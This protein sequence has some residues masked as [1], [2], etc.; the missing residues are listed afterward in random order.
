MFS[1]VFNLRFQAKRS[2]LYLK[3]TSAYMLSEEFCRSFK[4]TYFVERRQTAAFEVSA[5]NQ[6]TSTG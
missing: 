5:K 6:N 3:E 2:E 4:N 1:F